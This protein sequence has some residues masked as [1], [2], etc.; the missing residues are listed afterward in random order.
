MK[1][2]ILHVDETTLQVLREPG[3]SA[4]T[5]SYLWLY[6][7][8]CMGPPIVLYD[9]RSS[10]GG[11]LRC[12]ISIYFNILKNYEQLDLSALGFPVQ[13]EPRVLLQ[14]RSSASPPP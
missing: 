8:G 1:Q 7:N 12:I 6:R 2:D 9:Y 4:E 11:E 3:K 10:R 13:E 14:P 5:Q